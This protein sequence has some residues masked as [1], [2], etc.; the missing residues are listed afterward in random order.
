[1]SASRQDLLDKKDLKL[2]IEEMM[3]A[4]GFFWGTLFLTFLASVPRSA[5]SV[6]DPS[7]PMI[8][9]DLGYYADEY[10][11]SWTYVNEN[12]DWK[13]HISWWELHSVF[14]AFKDSAATRQA[15]E[16]QTYC[17][18]TKSEPKW[19][20]LWVKHDLPFP[21]PCTNT[22][23]L[24]DGCDGTESGNQP[25]FAVWKQEPPSDDDVVSEN[26]K[27]TRLVLGYFR[28]PWNYP[29][30]WDFQFPQYLD[31]MPMSQMYNDTSVPSCFRHPPAVAPQFDLA[32]PTQPD[33]FRNFDMVLPRQTNFAVGFE[34]G[35]E[36]YQHFKD[37]ESQYC[38]PTITTSGQRIQG[39][40]WTVTPIG[41]AEKDMHYVEVVHG[42]DC[43]AGFS[44]DGSSLSGSLSGRC[45]QCPVN[46]IRRITSRNSDYK[47]GMRNW[48]VVDE[49]N[50][51]RTRCEVCPENSYAVSQ[52]GSLSLKHF[53]CL[54]QIIFLH[55][56]CR[57]ILTATERIARYGCGLV[58]CSIFVERRRY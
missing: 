49:Q 8:T 50:P 13:S 32:K 23:A 35:E 58:A 26:N 53:H 43:P 30:N 18:C 28:D 56:G 27:Y 9:V 3:Q 34:D 17:V 51:G 48:T 38:P 40:H 54:G 57:V 31:D 2:K 12:N 25:P 42:G 24:I 10:Y 16:L 22:T 14:K 21:T 47:N 7:W 1:M 5:V 19:R 11:R 37:F 39:P 46:S 33:A 36:N 45:E 52:G 15:P 20:T 55:R 29:N 41:S 4:G 44:R 6:V